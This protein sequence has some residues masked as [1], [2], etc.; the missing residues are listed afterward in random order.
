MPVWLLIATT[1]SRLVSFAILTNKSIA[2]AHMGGRIAKKDGNSPARSA[3]EALGNALLGTN[4]NRSLQQARQIIG[5]GG[6]PCQRFATGL[7]LA[8]RHPQLRK[9][10]VPLR[11]ETTHFFFGQFTNASHRDASLENVHGF[12]RKL[13]P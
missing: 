1:M 5:N 6:L 11:F 7:Q 4:L 2:E 12:S 9:N 3:K 10:A 8:L 13:L